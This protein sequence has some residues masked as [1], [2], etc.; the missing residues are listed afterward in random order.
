MRYSQARMVLKVFFDMTANG[1]SVGRIV[2]KVRCWEVMY[3]LVLVALAFFMDQ[4]ISQTRSSIAW[5]LMMIK[6]NMHV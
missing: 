5:F 1:K 4:A 3:H 2:M 6:W